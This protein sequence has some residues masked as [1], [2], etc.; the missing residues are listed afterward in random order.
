[1][2]CHLCEDMWRHLSE[3]QE[4]RPFDIE[5]LDV[6]TDDTLKARY[7]TLVPVLAAEDRVL[8]NYYLDPI[9]LGLYLDQA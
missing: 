9:A 8:C 1:M 4:E 2:G 3:I 6:D 7:G 5:V